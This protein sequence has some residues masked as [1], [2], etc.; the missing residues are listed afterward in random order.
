MPARLTSTCAS[1][2]LLGL[3]VFSMAWVIVLSDTAATR[4]SLWLI[5][6]VGP[7]LLVLRGVLRTQSDTL[8][9]SS[10]LALIYLLHGGVIWWTDP[11]RS[12]WGLLEMVPALG[13]IVSA[14]LTIRQS[15]T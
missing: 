3:I 15:D 9:Y 14:G 7:W 4:I 6:F 8:L 12:G 1:G 10:L 5:L 2:S 13:H 11:I